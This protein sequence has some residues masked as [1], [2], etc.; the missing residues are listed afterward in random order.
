[1]K[2]IDW[3]KLTFS[4]TEC[5]KLVRCSYKD[6]AWG[7]LRVTTD[8]TIQIHAA[9]AA[10]QYAQQ[11]FEGLKAYRG[12]DGVIRLFRPLENARRLADS[13]KAMYMAVVP[14]DLFLEACRI[15]ILE[16]LDY[17]PPY[18]TG[19]TMY[20]RP[21]LIGTTPKVGVAPAHEF[22]FMVVATPIGPYF[23]AGFGTTPFIINRHVDRA[24]PLGT[25]QYKVGGNYAA[26][27][28]A[29]EPAHEQGLGVL[30]LD[31]KE[32]KYIDEC[33][34][35]NFIGIR[36]GVYVTPLS[37]SILPSI[38]N[39]SLRTLCYDFNIDVEERQIPVE[40]L[41]MFQETAAV[42]T[43]AAISPIS[44][45]YDPDKQLTY[46]YGDAPGPVCCRLFNTLRDIQFGRAED[47]HGWCTIIDEH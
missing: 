45:I 3:G 26:S 18:G 47:N 37:A 35:A 27:F 33:G 22:E 14:E 31:S 39:R 23:P 41:S 42:G 32:H 1:M 6:G 38:I 25:G 24:A 44:R 8:M 40:E 36:D 11:A 30:F 2:N 7:P 19:A 12:V 34:G 13:A 21:I 16:N 46:E 10:L 20:L 29:T 15:S 9:A 28:R 17:L 5:E 4:Y 43:G